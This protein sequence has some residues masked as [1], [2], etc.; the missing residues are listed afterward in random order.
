MTAPPRSTSEVAQAYAET[1][2]RLA[3]GLVVITTRGADGK[4]YGLLVSSLSSYSMRPPSTMVAI[5][6]SCRSYAPLTTCTRFGV[7][8]LSTAQERTAR[9]FARGGDAKFTHVPWH[10]EAAVP[11][12]ADV[13]AYLCCQLRQ[14]FTH[15]DHAI[16]IGE[17][18]QAEQGVGT[19]LVYYRRRFDWRLQLPQ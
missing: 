5:S 4:P 10:W 13:H 14:V 11:R 7:H 8:L 18:T 3:A 6:E 1:M 17:V 15:A 9:L 16:L 19:P 12:L 2:S